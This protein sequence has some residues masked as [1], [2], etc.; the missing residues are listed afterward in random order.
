MPQG[1]H[2]RTFFDVYYQNFF[3]IN[4][5]QSQNKKQITSQKPQHKK[6]RKRITFNNDKEKKD[7]WL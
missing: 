4:E 7:L 3:S 6:K 1:I 5:K 2:K